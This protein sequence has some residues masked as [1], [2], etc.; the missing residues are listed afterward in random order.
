MSSLDAIIHQIEKL[1]NLA[2]MRLKTRC[3]LLIKSSQESLDKIENLGL[4]G[5]YSVNHDCYRHACDVH[6][7]SN[8]LGN[9]RVIK[10]NIIKIKDTVAVVEVVEDLEEE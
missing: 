2:L 3:E 4:K 7:I 6:R 8:E 9:M 10:E 1:Q 5:Y